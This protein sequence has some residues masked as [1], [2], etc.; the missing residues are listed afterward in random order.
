LFFAAVLTIMGFIVNRMN[1]AITGMTASSGVN[2]FPSFLEISVTLSIVAAGFTL[3]SLAVKYL[4]VF[5]EAKEAWAGARSVVLAGEDAEHPGQVL[6]IDRAAAERVLAR[7]KP[8]FGKRVLAGLWVLL[9]VGFL[10]VGY[11]RTAGGP[12]S[13]GTPAIAGAAAAPVTAELSLPADYT[14]PKGAES[15]GG[16]TFSHESHVDRKTPRCGPCHNGPFRMTEPGKPV[17]GEANFKRI[18][19]G[20]LCAFCHDG[21]KAFSVQGDCSACHR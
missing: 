9:I 6:V 15:P 8:A 2:Y 4:P 10:A 17:V 16:V 12:A 5:P 11:S 21:K 14:F 1:V 20:D 3:F 13:S 18:H 19:E 7:T